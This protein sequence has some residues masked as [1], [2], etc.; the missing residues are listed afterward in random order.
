MFDGS[1]GK[2]DMGFHIGVN[3]CSMKT[4]QNL[5]A[6]RNIRLDRLLL[7]TGKEYVSDSVEGA[8]IGLLQMHHGAR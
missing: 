8:S 1:R 6:V 5:D 2:M 7:E 4:E 3:G